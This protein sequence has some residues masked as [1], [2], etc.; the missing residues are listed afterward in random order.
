MSPKVAIIILNWNGWEDTIECLESLYQINY[1]N[2][3]L[4]LVDNASKDNSVEKIKE[5]C[6]GNIRVISDFFEYNQ[7]NKP[8]KIIESTKEELNVKSKIE[9]SDLNKKL[10]IIKNDENYGFAEGNNIGMRYVLNNLDSDYILLLNNDT[11]VDKNFLKELINVAETGHKIGFVGPKIYYYDFNGKKDV[12]NFAGGKLNIL[13]GQTSHIGLNEVD[14][15]QHNE[16]KE[17]NYIEGSCILAKSEMIRKIGLID[18]SYFTYW[19]DNDW[20][21]RGYKSGYKSIYVPKARIWHKVSASNINLTKEY[22][23]TRNQ[24]W[25]IKKYA[26][27]RQTLSFLLYFFGFYFWFTIWDSLYHKDFDKIDSFLKG[28]FRGVISSNVKNI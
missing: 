7:Y 26:T 16:I 28:V 23:F 17:V 18:P 24:L 19:E 3:D 5:Y 20:C 13:K 25:F 8:L 4:I 27:N 21:M 15:G 11:V 10:F 12:I 1:P 22:Y 9:R 14:N 2:F 6:E